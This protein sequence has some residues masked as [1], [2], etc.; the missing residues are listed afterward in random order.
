[1]AIAELQV[2]RRDYPAA[3]AAL[4]A[5]TQAMSRA[6]NPDTTLRARA[7]CAYG[8]VYYSTDDSARSRQYFS[9]ALALLASQSSAEAP[10][11]RARAR[12]GVAQADLEDRQYDQAA[13]GFQQA[14]AEQIASSGELHPRVS[15][16][17]NELGSL[18]YLRGGSR[19]SIPYF[20]RCLAIERKIYGED[21][22]LTASAANNLARVLL[23]QRDFAEAEPLLRAAIKSISAGVPETSD[24]MAFYFANL[25][26][27]RMGVGDLA[28]AQTLFEKGLKAAVLNKH[29]LHGP[30][31][32]DLADLECRT[33]RYRAGL[34]RLEEA[35][36]IVAARYAD[37]PWRSAHVDNVRAGCLAGVRRYAEASAL[38]QTSLP[39]VLKKWPAD[40]LFGHD[41]L[42]RAIR[43]Y[44][45][46]GDAAKVAHYSAMLPD[47]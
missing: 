26:L 43:L 15:E 39:V 4:K 10:G 11:L 12:E 14:L 27:V 46:A 29:R 32:S 41:A 36:P 28:N 19:A 35:R 23:E 24:D 25:A 2:Q 37:D 3:L 1:V 5:A 38:M 20:R 9:E 47:R 33:G 7:L 40:T 8:D 16:I 21:N 45:R 31:L 18:E 17:L 44:T 42:T 22:A 34:A 13:S 30:I 6:V